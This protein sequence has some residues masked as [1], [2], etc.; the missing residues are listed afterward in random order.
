M[1][2]KL[3]RYQVGR[4][5]CHHS[6]LKLAAFWI[7]RMQMQNIDLNP[8]DDGDSFWAWKIEASIKDNLGHKKDRT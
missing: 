6:T 7:I 1:V 3:P 2:S 5:I 4:Y 8:N